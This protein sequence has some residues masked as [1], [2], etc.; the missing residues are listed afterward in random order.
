MNTDGLEALLIRLV[1][2]NEN[3]LDSIDELKGEITEIKNEMSWITEH[4]FAATL[5]SRIDSNAAEVIGELDWS[6]D[7]SFAKRLID[8]IDDVSS[9]LASI[10]ANTNGL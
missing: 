6:K 4:S 8:G 10:E 2:I 7:L 5:I 1:E 9:R 3:I